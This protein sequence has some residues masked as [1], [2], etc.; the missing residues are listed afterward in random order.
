M[1]A[2][3]LPK[4]HSRYDVQ[5]FLGHMQIQSKKFTESS[6]LRKID[7][8]KIE[9]KV[10]KNE[11]AEL[12]KEAKELKGSDLTQNS[13]EVE[14]VD[15]EIALLDELRKENLD[16]VEHALKKLEATF[17]NND[18]IGRQIDQTNRVIIA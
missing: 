14:E 6:A 5:A 9:R 4:V 17:S 12:E 16:R 7:N 8:V 10:M 15:T 18:S 3:G 11:I 1:N 13:V 2:K